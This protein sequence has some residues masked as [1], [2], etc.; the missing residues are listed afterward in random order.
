M[1][2]N[3]PGR[4]NRQD[5]SRLVSA[6][7]FLSSSRPDKSGSHSPKRSENGRDKPLVWTR[8]HVRGVSEAEH[9]LSVVLEMPGVD[10]AVSTSASKP[11]RCWSRVAGFFEVRGPAAR[12]TEYNVGHYR[13][14][15]SLS[16]KIDL[17]AITAELKHGVL[18]VTLPK[19]QAAKARRIEFG[20]G[21]HTRR[22]LA[23]L[24]AAI[25]VIAGNLRSE[26]CS[27]CGRE[28]KVRALAPLSLP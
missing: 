17:E 20:S 12:L 10:K 19:A 2:S 3:K 25:K 27:T 7:R 5:G 1:L 15:F 16:N 13:R 6:A 8:L 21:R 9:A 14:P 4:P 28:G 24:C 23:S 22:S 26:R 11:G 18:T